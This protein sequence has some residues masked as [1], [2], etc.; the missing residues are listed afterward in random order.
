[1]ETSFIADAVRSPSNNGVPAMV[2]ET[3]V[4]SHVPPNSGFV[5]TGAPPDYNES[6]RFP[7]CEVSS[8][9]TNTESDL[10]PGYEDDEPTHDTH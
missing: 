7:L 9:P 2:G 5:L 10:P 3:S 1:M 6:N 8:V 4:E